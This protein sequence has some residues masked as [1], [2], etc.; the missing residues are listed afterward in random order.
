MPGSGLVNVSVSLLFSKRNYHQGAGDDAI[1]NKLSVAGAKS[2][3]M[4]FPAI[5]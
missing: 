5:E 4:P 2:A 1:F 3:R